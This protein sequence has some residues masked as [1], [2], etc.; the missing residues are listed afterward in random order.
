MWHMCLW[1]PDF[2]ISQISSGRWGCQQ[3]TFLSKHWRSEEDVSEETNRLSAPV[4]EVPD[5]LVLLAFSAQ[6]Q[7]LRQASGDWREATACMAGQ[8]SWP[9]GFP[10]VL[11]RMWGPRCPVVGPHSRLDPGIQ[12]GPHLSDRGGVRGAPP[13][14]LSGSPSSGRQSVSSVSAGWLLYQPSWTASKGSETQ[15]GEV[16]RLFSFWSEHFHFLLWKKN[17]EVKSPSTLEARCSLTPDSG[18]LRLGADGL[19]P[20]ILSLQGCSEAP[21]TLEELGWGV[22]THRTWNQEAPFP[23]S[24]K[25][26]GPFT[27]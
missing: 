22:R 5:T 1:I 21:L 19:E 27:G 4:L 20:E 18:Q 10:T 16:W 3:Q 13:S 6:L 23:R 24:T 25:R 2:T 17:Q 15:P 14:S 26:C 7:D 8:Q 12:Q 11:G 9:P